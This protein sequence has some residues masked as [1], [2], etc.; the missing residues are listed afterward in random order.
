M[1][2]RYGYITQRRFRETAAD[3]YE[4]DKAAALSGLDSP[5]DCKSTAHPPQDSDPT[6][7]AVNHPRHYTSHPSGVEAIT[8]CEHMNFCRGNAMKYLWRAGL[9]NNNALE[10]LR[11]AIWY[12]NRE[13]ARLERE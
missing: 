3:E 8:V 1:F 4:A 12:M 10:D 6:P 11:K 7:E 9:K 5:E 2:D 13:I